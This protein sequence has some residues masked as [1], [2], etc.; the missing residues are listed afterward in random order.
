MTLPSS[1]VLAQLQLVQQNLQQLVLQK[2]QVQR[3]L[4]ETDSALSQLRT[5]PKAYRIIGALMVEAAKNELEKELTEK[6]E[7]FTLR[8]KTLDKQEETLRKKTEEL[9]QQVSPRGK[10]HE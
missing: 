5:T 3:S 8:L 2:Q 1:E 6:K 9:Q 4:V 10:N 7:I